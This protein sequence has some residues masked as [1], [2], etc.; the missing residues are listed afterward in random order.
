LGEK[1]NQNLPYVSQIQ[2]LMSILVQKKAEL[3][4][5]KLKQANL[6]GKE[7]QQQI[8]ISKIKISIDHEI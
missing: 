8:R 2:E 6:L 3:K 5:A 4:D 1:N 7:E